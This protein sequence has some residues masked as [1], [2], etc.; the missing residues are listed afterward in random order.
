MA[1]ARFGDIVVAYE[2]GD[3]TQIGMIP[4]QVNGLLA[5]AEEVG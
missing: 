4:H 1:N 2:M 3:Q 5:K